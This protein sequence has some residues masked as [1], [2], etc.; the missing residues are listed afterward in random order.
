MDTSSLFLVKIMFLVAKNEG[1]CS[2]ALQGSLYGQFK[3]TINCL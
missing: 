1:K 3:G 2:L